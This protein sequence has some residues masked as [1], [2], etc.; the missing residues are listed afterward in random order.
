MAGNQ[1]LQLATCLAHPTA[2]AKLS[3]AADTLATYSYV[4]PYFSSSCPLKPVAS[5]LGFSPG[6]WKQPTEMLGPWEWVVR[7][8]LWYLPFS[9]QEWKMTVFTDH[10]PLTHAILL[11]YDPQTARLCRYLAYVAD[12]TSNILHSARPSTL[13][14]TI[15]RSHQA[16][17]RMLHGRSLS[18]SFPTGGLGAWNSQSA[19]STSSLLDRSHRPLQR[20]L[21][22]CHPGCM[23]YWQWSSY[24]PCLQWI[25]R[26]A[27]KSAYVPDDT[28]GQTVLFLDVSRSAT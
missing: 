14:L 18:S 9:P 1:A 27:T 25:C 4:G 16:T 10:Q 26:H 22:V 3:L 2:D 6:S 24:P 7:G 28:R 13:W 23:R 5:K 17:W 21:G 8:L 12:Y 19:T 11:I 20:R 15:C